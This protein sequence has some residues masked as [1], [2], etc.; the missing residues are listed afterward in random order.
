MQVPAGLTEDPLG[1]TLFALGE[2]HIH[3]HQNRDI[4]VSSGLIPIVVL[5]VFL[6]CGFRN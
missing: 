3:P 6:A 1:L 2:S 5:V 4:V